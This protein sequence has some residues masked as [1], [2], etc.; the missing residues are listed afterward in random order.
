VRV[1]Y[2]YEANGRLH[3]RAKVKGH[4]AE[5]A[6][7]FNHE[8]CLPDEEVELWAHFIEEELRDKS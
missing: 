5:V 6:T 7:D 2:T 8:N 1:S 4:G 3:V